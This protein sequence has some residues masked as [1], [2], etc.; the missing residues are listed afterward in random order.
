M[1]LSLAPVAGRNWFVAALLWISFLFL[2]ETTLPSWGAHGI[3]R[4]FEG[5]AFLVTA[6]V[7]VIAT[8]TVRWFHYGERIDLVALGI[9]NVCAIGLS[10]NGLYGGP[11]ASAF[12]AAAFVASAPLSQVVWR[13]AVGLLATISYS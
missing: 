2:N 13:R 11:L 9:A 4:L 12:V 7:P 5:K 1:L 6:L 8:L 3:V 10:A